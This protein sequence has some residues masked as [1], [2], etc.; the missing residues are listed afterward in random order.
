VG[1]IPPKIVLK[2]FL[3]YDEYDESYEILPDNTV[4]D[5]LYF[6]GS[7]V[8]DSGILNA[9]NIFFERV[10][11]QVKI[12]IRETSTPVNAS[13]GYQPGELVEVDIKLFIN[14]IASWYIDDFKLGVD[15]SGD[16]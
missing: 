3:N 16:E 10:V 7:E 12:S 11:P 2:S 14:N 1:Q 4:V 5:N 13:I 6:N 15:Y 8:Y 9:S